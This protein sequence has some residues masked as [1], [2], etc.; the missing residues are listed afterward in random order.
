MHRVSPLPLAAGG[1]ASAAESA[2]QL[3]LPPPPPGSSGGVSRPCL[4]TLSTR[5]SASVRLRRRRTGP[6][7][8]CDGRRAEEEAAEEEGVVAAAAVGVPS[9]APPA[10]ACCPR[11]DGGA[12]SMS[13]PV[14]RFHSSS[15]RWRVWA[16]SSSGLRTPPLTLRGDKPEMP[17]P[18]VLPAK[19][20]ELR[21]GV[22]CDCGGGR[23]WGCC[24]LEGL[25]VARKEE[26]GDD[27]DAAAAG[28]DGAAAA[29]STPL[30]A[31]S[32]DSVG[33]AGRGVIAIERAEAG[34]VPLTGPP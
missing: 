23:R 17:L 20:L 2:P 9:S 1:N 10:A 18:P 6:V 25:V 5:A 7:K 30:V 3:L 24:C 29:A 22:G 34:S 4:S 21:G 16:A 28:D 8:E 13:W 15:L 14:M 11:G 33:S 27:S 32:P 31:V 19:L 12:G 26:A